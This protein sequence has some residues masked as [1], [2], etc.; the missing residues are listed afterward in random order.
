MADAPGMDA[1]PSRARSR[2]EPPPFGVAAH[3]IDNAAST[4][5]KATEFFDM[6]RNVIQC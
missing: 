5:S 1:A 4:A 3:G 6:K 2:N